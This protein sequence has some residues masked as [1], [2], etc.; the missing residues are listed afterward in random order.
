MNQGGTTKQ[1]GQTAS[2]VGGFTQIMHEQMRGHAH[3]LD[4]RSEG[5]HDAIIEEKESHPGAFVDEANLGLTQAGSGSSGKIRVVD[6]PHQSNFDTT[7]P[8]APVKT[9]ESQIRQFVYPEQYGE[10]KPISYAMPTADEMYG[11]ELR[12]LNQLELQ[13]QD[14]HDKLYGRQENR[15]RVVPLR[16]NLDEARDHHANAMAI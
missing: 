8:L 14:L 7:N 10:V 6:K 1:G 11:A 9:T 5:N 16:D 2:T 13:Q 12:R 15:V 4:N 3:V